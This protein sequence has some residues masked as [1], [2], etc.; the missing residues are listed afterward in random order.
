MSLTNK[1]KLNFTLFLIIINAIS[2]FGDSPVINYKDT[3]SKTQGWYFGFNIGAYFANK[4]TANYYNGSGVN[5]IT[6]VINPDNYSYGYANY[7]YIYDKL[8][9]R[10]FFIDTTQ[11]PTNM[12]YDPSINIGFHFR[13]VMKD[14]FSIFFETD[15]AKLKTNGIVI[16]S[17]INSP[18]QNVD[19]L[20]NLAPITGQE[21][22]VDINVG[23]SKGFTKGLISPFVAIGLNMNNVK[24]IKSEIQIA[25]KIFNYDNPYYSQ[26][27]IKQGGIAFGVFMNTGLEINFGNDAMLNLVGNF[28]YKRINLYKNE[29]LLFNCTIYAQVI[30]KLSKFFNSDKN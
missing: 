27:K 10:D 9:S 20:T 16:L 22:R 18:Y 7:Q 4:Q 8:G 12:K 5:R 23:L 29:K 3:L 19:S 2:C 15:Y 24:Y 30:M 26:Y 1:I 28:N 11:F 6:A 21:E 13:K 25:G 14:K 17:F